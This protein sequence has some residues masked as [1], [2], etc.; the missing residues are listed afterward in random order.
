MVIKMA[1]AKETMTVKAGG[2][3]MLMVPTLVGTH[4]DGLRH[5][6]AYDAGPQRHD[7]DVHADWCPDNDDE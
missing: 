3:T 4:D 1:H 2:I 5:P 6:C 7:T